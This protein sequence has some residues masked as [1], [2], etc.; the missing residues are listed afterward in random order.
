MFSQSESVSTKFRYTTKIYQSYLSLSRPPVS[1]AFGSSYVKSY[2]NYHRL[3]TAKVQFLVQ[4]KRKLS[5]IQP[6]SSLYYNSNKC[7]R[8]LSLG[9][10]VYQ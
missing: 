9:T 3:A 8:L 7:D 2:L 5:N 6:E 1:T 4:V 10:V